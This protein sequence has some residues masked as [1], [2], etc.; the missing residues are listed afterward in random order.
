MVLDMC[1]EA[2]RFT[3]SYT[4]LVRGV[5]RTKERTKSHEDGP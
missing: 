1:N 2:S 3:R 5:M 4:I